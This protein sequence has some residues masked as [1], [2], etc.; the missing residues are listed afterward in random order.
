VDSHGVLSL[1]PSFP[2]RRAK[3]LKIAGNLRKKGQNNYALWIEAKVVQLEHA[4]KLAYDI[5]TLAVAD[6]KI[7]AEA[8]LAEG[9]KF[10]LKMKL[11]ILSRLAI[12]SLSASDFGT[13]IDIIR[14]G[15]SDDEPREF[16]V[17]EPRL[18]DLI[19]FMQATGDDSLLEDE[20]LSVD[21]DAAS[22]ITKKPWQEA[23]S[24]FRCS[25]VFFLCET[26]CQTR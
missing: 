17:K 23:A 20:G 19:A 18:R 14:L 6:I 26:Q 7:H 13:F 4:Q 12:V 21:D 10:P 25:F 9:I 16:D 15:V 11:R 24:P 2:Q 8:L 5:D 1:S 22:S 3:A